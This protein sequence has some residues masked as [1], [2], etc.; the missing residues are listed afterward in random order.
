MVGHAFLPGPALREYVKGYQLWHF[1]F[2]DAGNLP[3][4]AYAP[5]PEQALVF[6]PRSDG[7]PVSYAGCDKIIRRTR[8]F[9]TGQFTQRINRYIGSTD[10]IILLVNFQPGVLHRLTGIPYW[11]LTNTV[12]DA[13]AVFSKEIR[14]V[15]ERLNSTGDPLEMIAIV[16]RF[17]FSQFKK[18]KRDAHPLDAVTNL[19]VDQPQNSKL[20]QLA[21][22]SFLC[23][24]QFERKF[25]ERMG[26]SPKLYAR[27]ARVYKAYCIKY[28][29]SEMDW[30]SVALVCGYHDYQ[31]LV[32]DFQDF[33]GVT[34]NLYLLEDNQSPERLSGELD[35]S[36]QKDVVFLPPTH[37]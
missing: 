32:K 5:R 25:K 29:Y 4:K 7:E 36:L 31:H 33:A 24:R 21:K 12:A 1:V 2:T 23:V 16:E 37:R 30:L 18:I 3:F 22:E 6:C 10:Y 19:L 15:N 8:S 28:H 27:I 20:I 35:S 17:L 9:I 14:L 26:I 34:P 13:E 11:E